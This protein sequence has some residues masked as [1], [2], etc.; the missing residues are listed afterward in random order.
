MV[1]L[2]EETK[3]LCGV[4][5]TPIQQGQLS[6][7]KGCTVRPGPPASGGGTEVGCQGMATGSRMAV[8]GGRS[9]L[10]GSWESRG[11]RTS[12]VSG[13]PPMSV[14]QRCGGVW[15]QLGFSCLLSAGPSCQ[16]RGWLCTWA[17]LRQCPEAGKGPGTMPSH[18]HL[19]LIILLSISKLEGVGL[20][21]AGHRGPATCLGCPPLFI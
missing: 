16:V 11:P 15:G 18:S 3:A 12:L 2:G 8:G 13:L 19:D 17:V 6:Q 20:H 10:Q 4:L 7:H 1:P 14:L 9:V 21:R 5:P